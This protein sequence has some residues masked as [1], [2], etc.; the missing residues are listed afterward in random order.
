MNASTEFK[1]NSKKGSVINWT[2]AILFLKNQDL[3]SLALKAWK[4]RIARI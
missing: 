2:V 1:D 3:M 4:G